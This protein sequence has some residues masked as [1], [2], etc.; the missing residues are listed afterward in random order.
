MNTQLSK[1][2]R[3]LPPIP[4]TM[5]GFGRTGRAQRMKPSALPR[6]LPPYDRHLCGMLVAYPPLRWVASGVAEEEV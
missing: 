4:R 1:I 2:I 6:K 5:S 3:P